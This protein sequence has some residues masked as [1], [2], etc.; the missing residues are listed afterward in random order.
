M[1]IR[2]LMSIILTKILHITSYSAL[3]KNIII[4]NKRL[5]ILIYILNVF[6]IVFDDIF[7]DILNEFAY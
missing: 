7:I 2:T 6:S 1:T 5:H 3:Y 4:Y